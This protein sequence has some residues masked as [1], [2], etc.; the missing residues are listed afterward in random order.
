MNYKQSLVKF[1]CLENNLDLFQEAI[2]P[3]SCGG[4]DLFKFFALIGDKILDLSLIEL[5]SQEQIFDT[6]LLTPKMN[7]LHNKHSLAKFGKLLSIKL[8]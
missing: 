4:S 2:S 1:F 7:L 6:G 8:K 3:K 5:Y